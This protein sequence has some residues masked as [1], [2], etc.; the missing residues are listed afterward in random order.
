[1]NETERERIAPRCKTEA[2]F[3]NAS[4]PTI[5]EK[6]EKTKEGSS[7]CKSDRIFLT[8]ALEPSSVIFIS[9]QPLARDITSQGGKFN[10]R[11]GREETRRKKGK[12][13]IIFAAGGE[14]GHRR[15]DGSFFQVQ[16]RGDENR[17]LTDDTT[18][19]RTR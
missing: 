10:R 11:E 12:R 16:G 4:F 13:K 7:T 1:M 19:D 14:I 2:V 3:G 5:E 6:K 15:A 18:L 9:N 8:Y 17:R